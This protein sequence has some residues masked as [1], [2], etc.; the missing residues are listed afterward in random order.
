MSRNPLPEPRPEPPPG[1]P[2]GPETAPTPTPT[3]TPTPAPEL[4]PA[5]PEGFVPHFRKSP[6]TAPWEPLFSR[7][8]AQSVQ[9]GLHIR[10]AHCN[11]RGFVHGGLISALADNAM[12]M[13][14]G[15]QAQ[16]TEGKERRPVTINLA[17]DFTGS[18][19]V[20]QWLSFEPRVLKITRTLAFVDCVVLADDAMLARA[21][22]T[23]RLG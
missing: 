10:E 17:V 23:F 15:Q 1:L 13:S 7:R 21:N 11:S 4:E 5:P 14:A 12:G 18:G 9:I 8:T 19:Q 2:P 6:L 20:G 16:Q 22:A 3:P